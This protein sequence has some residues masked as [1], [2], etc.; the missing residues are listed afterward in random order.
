MSTY[1]DM[2]TWL[3]WISV[4]GGLYL[5][6]KSS[7]AF[8]DGAAAVARS[9]GISPFIVG[10]VVIGFGTS[11]PELCVSTLSGLSDHASLSLGNAYGSCVFNIAAILG[12]AAFIR[13]ISV[14]PSAVW[15][16]GPL[17]TAIS[18]GSL[19]LLRDGNC[20]R[21]D[22][23]VFVAAFA[24]IMPLYCIVDQK[25]SGGA[26]SAASAPGGGADSPRSVTL[27]KTGGGTWYLWEQNLLV[28]IRIPTSQD[29]WA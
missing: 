4:V 17:L 14:K 12:V 26:A 16:A 6:A 21:V 9:L 27:R 29:A 5:L 18:V 23:A 24:L 15:L 25:T 11:A 10:M 22:A 2:P 20:S 7:D 8:V 19:F 3:A 28:D 13:P 1:P